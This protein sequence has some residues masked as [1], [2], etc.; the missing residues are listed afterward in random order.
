MWSTAANNSN[1]KRKRNG[2][3]LHFYWAISSL[4]LNIII[5]RDSSVSVLLVNQQLTDLT[6]LLPCC[7][8]NSKPSKHNKMWANIV[9]RQAGVS[10]M[11][12]LAHGT[13][14]GAITHHRNEMKYW[15]WTL[16]HALCCLW[17]AYECWSNV[18]AARIGL[19]NWIECLLK[20]VYR[21]RG[22]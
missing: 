1:S 11:I 19:S 5:P 22:R 10:I 7:T 9:Q 17:S 21:E 4:L 16:F 15:L 13:W 8:T 20:T 12:L 2:H 6:D 18:S 14:F 3:D